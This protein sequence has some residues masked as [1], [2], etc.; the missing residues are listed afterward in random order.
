MFVNVYYNVVFAR[1]PIDTEVEGNLV[2]NCHKNPR[3]QIFDKLFNDVYREPLLL[4]DFDQ[5]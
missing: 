1:V 3:L 5:N 2:H 4:H